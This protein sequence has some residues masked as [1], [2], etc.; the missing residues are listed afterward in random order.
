MRTMDNKREQARLV[1][2]IPSGIKS[3]V[4][5]YA[6]DTCRS[7]NESLIYLVKRGLAAE[8]SASAHTA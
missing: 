2:R 3:E 5:A 8:K 1:F 4:D 6:T 7:L